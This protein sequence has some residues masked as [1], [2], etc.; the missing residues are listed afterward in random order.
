M[1]LLDLLGR[2]MDD[3]IEPV[4]AAGAAARPKEKTAA[5]GA[6]PESGP[7]GLRPK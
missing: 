2:W 5:G 3:L 7:G 1:A 4:L 6:A